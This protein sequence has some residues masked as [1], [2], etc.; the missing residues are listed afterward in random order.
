MMSSPELG[1]A[2]WPWVLNLAERIRDANDF[3]GL[4]LVVADGNVDD[5]DIEYC[6]SQTDKPLTDEE[7]KLADDLLYS[8]VEIRHFAYWLSCNKNELYELG[9]LCGIA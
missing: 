7:K 2:I 6:M 5:E 8:E 1:G 9:Y 3:G 4:H